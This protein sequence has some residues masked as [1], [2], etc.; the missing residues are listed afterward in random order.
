MKARDL[1][2]ICKVSPVDEVLIQAKKSVG[3][4]GNEIGMGKVHQ[5]VVNGIANGRH[6]A[7]TVAT[8]HLITSGVSNWGGSALVAAPA[9]LNQCPVHSPHEEDQLKCIVGL[10]VCDGILQKREMSVNGQPF[11]LVH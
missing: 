1:C 2:D 4:A 6:I 7:N 5:R 3:D 10:G 9:I 11:H 8:D